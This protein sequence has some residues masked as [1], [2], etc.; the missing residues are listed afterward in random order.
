M[1]DLDK[2]NSIT[3]Y[4]S[5]GTYHELTGKGTLTDNVLEPITKP[6]IGYVTEK[7]D[8]TNARIIINGNDY[9]IGSR[10][11]LLY[12]KGDRIKNNTLGIVEELIPVAE[13]ISSRT[14]IQDDIF[15]I[16][17]EVYGYNIGR[18]Y[19]NYTN[20]KGLDFRVFDIQLLKFETYNRLLNETMDKISNWREANSQYFFK[21]HNMVTLS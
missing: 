18:N 14:Q 8:G 13:K 19:K 1:E 5:I 17:G 16:Y 12:A 7:I 9:F 3:K 20:S 15:V 4:P 21:V 11:Q 6:L 10:E 2:L